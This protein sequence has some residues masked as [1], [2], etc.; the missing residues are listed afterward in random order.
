[1][2]IEHPIAGDAGSALYRSGG[3]TALLDSPRRCVEKRPQPGRVL[4]GTPCVF[5]AALLL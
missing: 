3:K 5:T 1:M 2:L 4:I